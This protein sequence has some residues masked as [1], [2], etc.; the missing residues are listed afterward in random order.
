MKNENTTTTRPLY[1]IAAEI[2]KDWIKVN[3]AAKPYL[4]A[5]GTIG[6][7]GASYGWDTGKSI[8]L[9]F[10]S[11]ASSWRGEKAKQIKAELKN[12]IK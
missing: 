10:L 11:N 1:T 12:L 3:Y 6:D 5:M 9:Y 2:R 7:V 8:V 4:D